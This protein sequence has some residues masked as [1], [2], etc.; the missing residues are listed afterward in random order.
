MKMD[1]NIK[2]Q[3][4]PFA[5]D[6]LPDACNQPS[7]AEELNLRSCD[8]R[9]EVDASIPPPLNKKGKIIIEDLL[10][11]NAEGMP[12]KD[13]ATVFQ[14]SEPAVSQALAKLKKS[15]ARPA[16]LD[17]L[18]AKEERFVMEI[19]GGRNQTQAALQAFDCNSLDSAKSIGSRLARD[20]DIAEAITAVLASEDLGTRKLVQ[21]LR[22][23]V[24]SRDPQASL[25]AVDMGFKLHGAYPATITKNLNLNVEVCPVDLSQYQM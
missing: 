2:T 18:T 21:R 7:A 6:F 5:I 1:T 23:H 12:Q 8:L 19:A 20:P 3:Y 9:P 15:A 14:V 10:R 11:M 13:I 17:K 4:D 22:D 16:V 25:R 24:E